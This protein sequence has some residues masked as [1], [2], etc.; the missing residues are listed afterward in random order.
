MLYRLVFN[1]TSDGYLRV[2]GVAKDL[3]ALSAIYLNDRVF[4]VA[5]RTAQLGSFQTLRLLEAARQARNRP[6]IDI[7]CEAVEI[8][9]NQTD[10]MRLATG[11]GKIA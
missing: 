5:V 11:K 6:G 9:Q 8:N 10:V 1:I 4:G 7:C 2:T 3:P